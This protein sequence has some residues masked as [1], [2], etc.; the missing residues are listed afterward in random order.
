M[1]A[2][3]SRLSF[4]FNAIVQEGKES[5]RFRIDYIKSAL[6]TEW[7]LSFFHCR[8]VRLRTRVPRVQLPLSEAPGIVYT[9]LK[10]RAQV[11][12]SNLDCYQSTP[13]YLP[14][15]PLYPEKYAPGACLCCL[16]LIT[17]P[18]LL[19]INLLCFNTE[20]FRAQILLHKN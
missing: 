10:K 3:F 15:P 14:P 13:F 8:G 11:I 19:R 20:I 6:N 17:M 5:I 16:Y 1:A 18:T 12:N 4:R 9:F 7:N 2:F